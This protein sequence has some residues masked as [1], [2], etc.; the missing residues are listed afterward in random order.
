[1]PAQ[2]VMMLRLSLFYLAVAVGIG[3]VL[4][5][6]KVQPLH[7]GVW[8][9][10]P[11]HFETAIWGW[12]IQFVMG[13]A[14]WMF[15]RFLKGKARGPGVL[16]WC[17]ITLFNTGLLLLISGY[18]VDGGMV[19]LKIMG[20]GFLVSSIFLFAWLIWNRVVSYRNLKH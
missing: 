4:L 11:I 6:H 9:L 7:P 2:T 15:P 17:M 19:N 8:A 1:M 3:G 18:F 10:L 20:R 14:Y 5:F 16:A 13:T 12:L